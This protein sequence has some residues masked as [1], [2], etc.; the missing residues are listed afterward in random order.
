[1]FKQT[2]IIQKV[3]S[4]GR[5]ASAKQLAL[6]GLGLG[7]PSTRETNMIIKIEVKVLRSIH[8]MLERAPGS[9]F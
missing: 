2:L 4:Q 9:E 3:G 7:R 1:M 6:R 8:I 5:G